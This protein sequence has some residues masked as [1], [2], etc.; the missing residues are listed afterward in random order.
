MRICTCMHACGC[1]CMY[2]HT[3]GGAD[4]CAPPSGSISDEVGATHASVLL[5]GCP[6]SAASLAS[7]VCSS[8]NLMQAVLIAAYATSFMSSTR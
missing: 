8:M 7:C 4:E 1:A 6:T 3:P 2:E 5:D